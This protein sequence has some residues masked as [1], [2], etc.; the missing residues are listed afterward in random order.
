MI[1]NDVY[2][3]ADSGFTG[4]PNVIHVFRRYNYE[5][6]MK[7]AFIAVEQVVMLRGN[8]VNENEI[9]MGCI[10][11]IFKCSISGF[12]LKELT[13]TCDEYYVE[14]VNNTGYFE[15]RGTAE[16]VL[17]EK[18][19]TE[20]ANSIAKIDVQGVVKVEMIEEDELINGKLST[21]Q[22]QECSLIEAHGRGYI[23]DIENN[24]KIINVY[25]VIQNP[26][27]GV[28]PVVN[29]ISMVNS[30]MSKIRIGIERHFGR[31]ILL[32]RIA[33][34][35]Y[36][37]KS[38]TFATVIKFAHAITNYHI[39]LHPMSKFPFEIFHRSLENVLVNG[40]RKEVNRRIPIPNYCQKKMAEL[41]GTRNVHK[42]LEE[43]YGEIL[44]I[45]INK[46]GKTVIDTEWEL[47]DLD[48]AVEE[49]MKIA[50]EKQN[51]QNEVEYNGENNCDTFG[52]MET[53]ET[54]KDKNGNGNDEAFIWKDK[55]VK[56]SS[57]METNVINWQYFDNDEDK[58]KDKEMKPKSIFEVFGCSKFDI[59]DEMKNEMKFIR[60]NEITTKTEPTGKKLNKINDY[61]HLVNYEIDSLN[62]MKQNQQLKI[63]DDFDFIDNPLNDKNDSMDIRIKSPKI[64]FEN[65]FSS[66]NL[67]NDFGESELQNTEVK[68]PDYIYDETFQMKKPN[69]MKNEKTDKVEELIAEP[70]EYSYGVDN[71]I[72]FSWCNS[73]FINCFLYCK[74]SKF[75]DLFRIIPSTVTHGIL[76][77]NG[78]G[79]PD[80]SSLM[81]WHD[82]V[83]TLGKI[84]VF[85]F[86]INNSHWTCGF[87]FN[88][89]KEIYIVD[90]L[91]PKGFFRSEESS[92]K[93][94]QSFFKE[95]FLLKDISIKFVQVETQLSGWE[96][97]YRL[98]HCINNICRNQT[99]TIKKI[100]KYYNKEDFNKF[101]L[102]LPPMVDAFNRCLKE[103][104][105]FYR[106]PIDMFHRLYGDSFQN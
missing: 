4:C 77:T 72:K 51:E 57:L 41:L 17:D 69:K 96:C 8:Y 44:D 65:Q 67:M 53:C 73:L 32:N 94:L 75:S 38:D 25:F 23:S 71:C 33:A 11:V 24:V 3:L 34:M 1:S 66:G 30:L 26:I 28:I 68:T 42:T 21:V 19:S 88:N 70:I 97:G 36:Q 14:D 29:T 6:A 105:P 40:E 74:R 61:Q 12:M 10:E 27:V 48:D 86:N 18:I 16:G 87:Y 39:H 91:S 93:S 85:I 62:Q 60:E 56:A 49:K 81:T 52:M 104:Q 101:L 78:S 47:Y 20:F 80:D 82:E 95:K 5:D 90:S 7:H 54:T 2:V 31:L 45:S 35:P 55:G 79:Y 58:E 103:F 22:R 83:M 50:I 59:P 9:L 100:Q 84:L 37:L 13:N 102:E 43:Y 76:T 15:F 46:Q 99:I 106:T 92:Y 64:S 89:K 63:H 98:L